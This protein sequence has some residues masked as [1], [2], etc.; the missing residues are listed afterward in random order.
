MKQYAR[1]FSSAFLVQISCHTTR[2]NG[3]FEIL[4]GLLSGS[5]TCV[6][7]RALD[8][9]D[10]IH[11]WNPALA[12]GSLV[13]TR[14]SSR[15]PAAF[16]KSLGRFLPPFPLVRNSGHAGK[17]RRQRRTCSIGGTKLRSFC[18]SVQKPAPLLRSSTTSSVATLIWI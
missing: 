18:E 4:L 1:I 14:R 11:T 5:I 3:A 13:T 9:L 7:A 16:E 6:L 15:S 2:S 10:P 8:L 12:V 17:I